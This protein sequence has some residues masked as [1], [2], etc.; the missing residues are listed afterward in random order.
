MKWLEPNIKSR[1]KPNSFY[2]FRATLMAHGNSQTRALIGAV[3]AS[4]YHSLRNLGSEPRLRP[5]PQLIAML[6]P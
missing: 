1:K 4:L 6:D 5:T 3:A 2:L